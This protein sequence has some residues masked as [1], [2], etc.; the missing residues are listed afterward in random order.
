MVERVYFCDMNYPGVLYLGTMEQF[1]RLYSDH[2]G[3]PSLWKRPV[4]KIG[5]KA[6]VFCE[7]DDGEVRQTVI[8]LWDIKDASSFCHD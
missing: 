7:L 2:G 4:C 8:E 1:H 6:A 3:Y 5:N